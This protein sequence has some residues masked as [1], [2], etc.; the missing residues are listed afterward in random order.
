MIPMLSRAHLKEDFIFYHFVFSDIVL[1]EVAYHIVYFTHTLRRLE[2]IEEF[3]NSN[4]EKS[5]DMLKSLG[6]ENYDGQVCYRIAFILSQ[7][8]GVT[9]DTKFA[10][11]LYLQAIS[12][13]GDSP[14]DNYFQGV[15]YQ[16]ALAGAG[17]KDLDKAIYHFTRSADRHCSVAQIKLGICYRQG[18]G[19]PKDF[20]K[21]FS[22]FQEAA[23]QGNPLGMS[24]LAYMY[25]AGLGVNG[26]DKNKAIELY[27]SAAEKN[28]VY[29]F[30]RLKLLKNRERKFVI[31]RK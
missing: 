29:A 22:L 6:S 9:K 28:D 10:E 18:F 15:I 2:A 12:L 4:Y 3:E 24:H 23:D 20:E 16:D 19:V 11:E 7:G 17:S 31:V 27:R 25:E 21:A 8:K 26:V 13:F 30:E 14:M 1:P 5:Y